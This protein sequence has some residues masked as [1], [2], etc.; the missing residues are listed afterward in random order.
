MFDIDPDLG[1]F[2]SPEFDPKKDRV[3]LDVPLELK[4][5]PLFIPSELTPRL[6]T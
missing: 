2:S 6:G 5:P 1:G 4:I 3:F